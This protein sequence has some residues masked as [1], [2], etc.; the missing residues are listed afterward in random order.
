M[1][2]EYVNEIESS[3]YHANK[4]IDELT[5]PYVVNINGVENTVQ[6]LKAMKKLLEQYQE[7][8]N[9]SMKIKRRKR[10]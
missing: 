4:V 6:S 8:I 5:R 2:I 3:L 7:P 1:D 10:N 9:I